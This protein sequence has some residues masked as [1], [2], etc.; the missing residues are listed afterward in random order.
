MQALVKYAN[1]PGKVE[2]RD[3]PRPTITR[4]QVLL[5]VRAVGICGSDLEM[6]HHKITFPVNPPV[7]LGHEFSGTVEEVGADVT[8]FAPGDRV[9]SET[10]A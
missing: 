1:E 9:V 7:I 5:R 3:M 8:D 4:D 6:Y 2:L 10:A